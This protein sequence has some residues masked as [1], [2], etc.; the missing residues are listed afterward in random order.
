MKKIL[1]T[2]GAGYL[3]SILTETLLK[4]GHSVTIL[5]NLSYNQLSLSGFCSN[6]NFNFVLGDVRNESLLEKLVNDNIFH[7]LNKWRDDDEDNDHD[8]DD[9]DKW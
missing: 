3:G 9:G 1:I 6:E 4:E 8:G 2:G 7:T 5:D